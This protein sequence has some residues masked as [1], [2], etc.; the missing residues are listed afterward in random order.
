MHHLWRGHA[1]L[2]CEAL[3][4]CP[5]RVRVLTLQSA[6]RL[7]GEGHEYGLLESALF[8][9]WPTRARLVVQHANLHVVSPVE[10]CNGRADYFVD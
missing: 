10:A 2:A 4:E 6:R 1:V 7:L 9:S 5:E 3:E 8:V